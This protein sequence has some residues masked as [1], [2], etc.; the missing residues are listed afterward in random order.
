MTESTQ[1]SQ[2]VVNRN[3]LV[4]YLN[5]NK[6]G[7]ILIDKLIDSDLSKLVWFVAISGFGFINIRNVFE[8]I[9]KIDLSSLSI[10][11][12]SIPWVLTS[13]SGILAYYFKLEMKSKDILYFMSLISEIE[14]FLLINQDIEITQVLEVINID[15]NNEKI[16]NIKKQVN[17]FSKIASFF[18]KGT[19]IFL[20]SSFLIAICVLMVYII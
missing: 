13:I 5:N 19:L 18:E 2:Q 8:G 10:L 17:Q 4:N 15:K 3:I 12:I 11:I 6:Q 14:A 1:K 7:Q 16:S 9:V 20:L